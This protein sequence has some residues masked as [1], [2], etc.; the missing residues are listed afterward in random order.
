MVRRAALLMLAFSCAPADKD[1]MH[2]ISAR[3]PLADD[4]VA[5]VADPALR[6]VIAD[7]WEHTM[8]WSPTYATT[9]G[10]HRYDDRLAPRDAASIAESNG[11][12]DAL[13]ARLVA[14]DASKLGETDHV[15][16]DLLRGRLEAAPALDVC[17]YHAGVRHAGGRGGMGGVRRP[18]QG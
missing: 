4:A 16:Y 13:L 14:L 1:T 12:R 15:T 5:G 3:S 9:L 7:H 10:D 8:K 2:T 17:K 11:E 6:A 18:L